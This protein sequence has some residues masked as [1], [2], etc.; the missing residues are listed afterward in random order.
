MHREG[1][2][3]FWRIQYFANCREIKLA[4]AVFPYSLRLIAYSFL[5]SSV[6]FIHRTTYA[7]TNTTTNYTT[8]H[9]A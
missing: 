7:I 2:F 5:I 4:R 9:C 6:F 1:L 8:D 3:I